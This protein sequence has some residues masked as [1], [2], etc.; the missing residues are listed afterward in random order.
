MTNKFLSPQQK[1]RQETLEALARKVGAGR[2]KSGNKSLELEPRGRSKRIDQ[3]QHKTHYRVCDQIPNQAQVSITRN[4]AFK[5]TRKLLNNAFTFSTER[6]LEHANYSCHF[7]FYFKKIIAKNALFQ[8]AWAGDD[9]YPPSQ[10]P[11]LQ[12]K[13]NVSNLNK[14]RF[15]HYVNNPWMHSQPTAFKGPLKVLKLISLS[16]SPFWLETCLWVLLFSFSS[17]NQR[18]KNQWGLHPSKL[19]Y[20]LLKKPQMPICSSRKNTY[21]WNLKFCSGK[22]WIS[23][24]S[25]V[26]ILIC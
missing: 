21:T 12:L 7:P 1:P 3:K 20:L 10:K 15:Q 24:L 9:K 26:G 13:I 4:I 6:A 5:T 22:I 25:W 18:N 11:L 16:T 19:F 23:S 8:E 17:I 2:K 14:R